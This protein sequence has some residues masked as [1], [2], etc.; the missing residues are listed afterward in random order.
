MACFRKSKNEE[1]K[2]KKPAKK[3]PGKKNIDELKSAARPSKYLSP[4]MQVQGKN[5]APSPAEV[6]KKK[7]Q[8]AKVKIEQPS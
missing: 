6:L 8:Q 1:S 5:E 7:T 2:A 4:S 3:V